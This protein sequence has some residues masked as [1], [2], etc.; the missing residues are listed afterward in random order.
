[1]GFGYPAWRG[2]IF[3]ILKAIQELW[4][5]VLPLMTFVFDTN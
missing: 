4:G 5:M 1:M 3:L 2:L